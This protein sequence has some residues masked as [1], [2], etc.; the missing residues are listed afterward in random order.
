MPVASSHACLPRVLEDRLLRAYRRLALDGTGLLLA[1]SGGADSTALLLASHAIAR[2]AALKLE[3][4]CLDH[5]VRAES[6]AEQNAVRVLCDTLQ[7]PF[8]AERLLLSAGSALESRARDARYQALA[9]IQK[10]AG[11]TWVATAHTA[12][13]QAETL[14]M[15]LG[16]GSS[17]RGAAGVREKRPPFVRPMLDWTRREVLAYLEARGQSYAQDAMNADDAFL[18]VRIRTEVLPALEQACEGAV[19][20]RLARFAAVAAEDDALLG[21]WAALAFARLTLTPNSL[22]LVGLRNLQRPLLRRVLALFFERMKVR[23]DTERIEGALGLLS[24]GPPLPTSADGTLR[25]KGGRLFWQ[26]NP[27]RRRPEQ[28]GATRSG[29]S[30]GSL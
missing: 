14:L 15:R 10:Q 25:V 17:L 6:A 4:A 9:A 5:G 27:P 12:S 2:A 16:R 23:V 1:V 13:D 18:R 21:D 3:V 26:V 8:H 28:I 7:V 24:G 19:A 20:V 22:D 30:T 11:L 29:R